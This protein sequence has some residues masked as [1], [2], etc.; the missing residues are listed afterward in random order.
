MDDDH[1]LYGVNVK[2]YNLPTIEREDELGDDRLQVIWDSCCEDFWM[3]VDSQSQERFGSEVYAEGRMGGW[4][5]PVPNLHGA[6]WGA[7]VALIQDEKKYYTEQ[8]IERVQEA[9]KEL[10][11]RRQNALVLGDN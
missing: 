7:F 8:Y 6:A 3:A 4:A 9:L 10:D 2:V 1:R 5:V 11:E